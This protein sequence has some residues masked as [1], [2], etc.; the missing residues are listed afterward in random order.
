MRTPK[1]IVSAF[2]A[3][4]T[5]ASCDGPVTCRFNAWCTKAVFAEQRPLFLARFLLL[6][7]YREQLATIFFNIIPQG[8]LLRCFLYSLDYSILACF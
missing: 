2:I 1:I 7:K 6:M 8:G 5:K 4:I 3:V